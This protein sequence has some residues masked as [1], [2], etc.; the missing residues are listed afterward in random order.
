MKSDRSAGIQYAALPFRRRGEAVEILL[1]TSRETRRWVI[2]KGWPMAGLSP[3]EC[4]SQEAFEEGGVRGPVGEKIGAY[5]YDKVLKDGSSRNLSV[6]VYPMD[7]LEE[8]ADW[9]EAAER[10]RRWFEGAQASSLV[11]E[12]ELADII[13]RFSAASAPRRT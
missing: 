2:P 8:L 13:L 1:L 4:A 6:E 12:P 11:D 3:A 5:G 9:P 10:D 7:V